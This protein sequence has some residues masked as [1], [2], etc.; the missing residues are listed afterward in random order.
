MAW[1]AGVG[2]CSLCSFLPPLVAQE[3][4]A[5]TPDLRALVRDVDPA[6]GWEIRQTGQVAGCEYVQ[7]HMVSQVW[8]GTKWRHV[9]LVIR[10]PSV[11]KDNQH[12]L[13]LIDGGSWREEWGEQGPDRVDLPAQVQLLAGMA[14]TWQTPVVVVQHIPFQPQLGGLKEDGLIALSFVQFLVTR[15]SRWPVLPAMVRAASRAMDAADAMSRERWG[16]GLTSFTVTGASKRGWTTWL[17]AAA[18]PRVTAIA[19]MVIDMLNMPAQLDH[20]LTSWGDYSEQIGDYTTLG[21]PA[22]IRSPVGQ[23]LVALVDPYSY[24]DQL[25]QP[26]LIILGTNDRYW[27]VDAI[28]MYWEGL[29]G[30]KHLLHIPNNGHGLKDTT[31]LLGTLGEFHRRQVKGQLLPAMETKMAIVDD[32]ALLLEVRAAEAPRAVRLWRAVAE[33]RDFRESQWD[34]QTLDIGANG[35]YPLACPRPSSGSVAVMT[36]LEFRAADGTPFY[37]S[38]PVQVLRGDETA[39]K[40]PK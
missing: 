6:F 37:L 28:N 11:V 17:S 27:P 1:F 14:Q 38:T 25:K 34:S 32:G 10:P 20:Q 40:S 35:W 24:R 31:R 9:M 13:L 33:Q 22:Q 30:P 8:Q 21:L 4:A 19:P 16:Q 23:A 12:A 5:T 26:K 36:E 15:D 18:D 3:A 29:Q 2:L 39:A 7:L